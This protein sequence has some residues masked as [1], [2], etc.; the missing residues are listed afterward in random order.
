MTCYSHLA[1]FSTSIN[2]F[3]QI[4]IISL[5]STQE[6]VYVYD[7]SRHLLLPS[8]SPSISKNNKH[9]KNIISLR[10][11]TLMRDYFSTSILT[12]FHRMENDWEVKRV[13]FDPPRTKCEEIFFFRNFLRRCQNSFIYICQKY[14]YIYI[15][16]NNE[17]K[18]ILTMTTTMMM[19]MSMLM[20]KRE[21]KKDKK[22]VFF[23]LL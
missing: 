3:Y 22:K 23:S 2:L 6:N 13:P 7:V 18:F 11:I 14:I 21:W 19:M 16:S 5:I 4:F 15:I 1:L 8:H 12:F 17:K 20:R 9:K 10:N